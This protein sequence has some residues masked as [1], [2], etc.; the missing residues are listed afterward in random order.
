MTKSSLSLAPFELGFVR[1]GPPKICM[2]RGRPVYATLF[3]SM[4]A[5]VVGACTRTSALDGV[6]FMVY[7]RCQLLSIDSRSR[8]R[9]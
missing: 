7:R 3:G 4:S 9:F 1:W 2:W 8:N 6:P 5:V